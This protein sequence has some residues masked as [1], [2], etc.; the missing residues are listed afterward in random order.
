MSKYRHKDMDKE[1]DGLLYEKLSH[2]NEKEIL[3]KCSEIKEDMLDGMKNISKLIEKANQAEEWGDAI[4]LLKNSYRQFLSNMDAILDTLKFLD[5]KQYSS[6]FLSGVFLV[7]VV[8]VYEGFM[9][10]MFKAYCEQ[11]N[12]SRLAEQ[13]SKANNKKQDLASQFRK[14]TLNNPNEVS[15]KYGM[16]GISIPELAT[17]EF[18]DIIEKRNSFVHRAG[19]AESGETINIDKNYVFWAAGKYNEIIYMYFKCFD[20][21]ALA[22]SEVHPE[23]P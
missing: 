23:N 19:V 13:K 11:P 3:N 1:S 12:L 6:S 22:L 8:S 7:G 17:N 18:K 21:H 14:M 16:F 9:H 20:K 5:E 4:L 10:E 2:N 15:K